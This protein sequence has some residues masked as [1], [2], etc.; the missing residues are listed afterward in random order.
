MGLLGYIEEVMKKLISLV[1]IFYFYIGNLLAVEIKPFGIEIGQ[2]IN[3]NYII[4]THKLVPSNEVAT[5]LTI[6]PPVKNENFN[7]Y[8][9]SITPISKRVLSISAFEFNP[10][11]KSLYLQNEGNLKREEKYEKNKSF[12]EG[13]AIQLIKRLEVKE[14]ART[15]EKPNFFILTLGNEN[16]DVQIRLAYGGLFREPKSI[17]YYSLKMSQLNGKEWQQFHR[18]KPEDLD[19]ISIE[20]LY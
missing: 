17:H 6:N 13:V 16:D 11:D 20:G 2:P 12:L 3:E 14:L 7:H 10:A 1:F 5:L 9:V 18:I 4:E 8:S 15:E 19:E